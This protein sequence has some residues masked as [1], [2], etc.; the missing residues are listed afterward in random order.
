M[1]PKLMDVVIDVMHKEVDLALQAEDIAGLERLRS[2]FEHLMEA[3]KKL[4]LEM[5]LEELDHADESG[6]LD[7]KV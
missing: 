7:P 4:K 6:S 3:G 2:L 5:E 1:K